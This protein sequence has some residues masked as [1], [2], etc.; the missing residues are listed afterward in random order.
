M[1][2]EEASALLS[3]VLSSREKQA[4]PAIQRESAQGVEAGSKQLEL[5]STDEEATA[6][7]VG[8]EDLGTVVYLVAVC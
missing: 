3:A 1:G 4:L 5:A 8:W 2:K 7:L 6:G